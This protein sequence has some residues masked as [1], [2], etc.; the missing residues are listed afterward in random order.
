M[1]EKVLL[2]DD[3]PS[4]V[5]SLRYTLERSGFE[6]AVAVDGPAALA[7]AEAEWPDVILLDVMLPGL[8]G[9]E[10]CRRLRATVSAP[11]VMLS[12][13]D[14]PVDR[15]VGLE[16]GADDYVTKPFS[17]R[18]LVARVRA[19]LRREQL[20]RNG[21]AAA[22]ERAEQLT[23]GEVIEV[24]ELRVDVGRRAVLRAGR[25][26][27]LNRRVFDLLVYMARNPGVVLTRSQLLRAVWADEVDGDSRT[28]DVHVRRLRR[29]VEPDPARPRLV[30]TVRGVGYVLRR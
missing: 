26:L 15:V 3:E 25:P 2:V 5:A 23:G 4:L 14:D 1:P 17:V 21:P 6:V 8:D 29:Q 11:I 16:V 10:V 28:V 19:H 9:F 7:A 27:A 20:R 24:G 30:Q 12:A 13:R 22:P 18:E